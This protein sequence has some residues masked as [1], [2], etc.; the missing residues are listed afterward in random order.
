VRKVRIGAEE[1]ARG[2]PVNVLIY[3]VRRH[4]ALA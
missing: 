3:A 1:I 4:R 2:T